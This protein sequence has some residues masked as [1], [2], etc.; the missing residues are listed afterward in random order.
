MRFSLKTRGIFTD[1]TAAKQSPE[2]EEPWLY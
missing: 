2:E 1:E